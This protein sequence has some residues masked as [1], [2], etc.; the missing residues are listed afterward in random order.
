MRIAFIVLLA[1][2]LPAAAPAWGPVGHRSVGHIADQ[3]ISSQTRQAVEALLGRESLAEASLWADGIRNEPKWRKTAPWHYVNIPDGETYDRSLRE[4][5]GDVIEALERFVVVLRFDGSNR[6]DK[7]AALRFVV[8]FVGDMHQPLHV[9]RASDRGGNQF[10]VNWFGESSNLHRVWDSALISRLRLS[11]K[12]LVNALAARPSDEVSRWAQADP[13]VWIEESMTLRPL[14]YNTQGKRLGR[15][16]LNA[17]AP[18]VEERLLQ[19]GV[20][21]AALLDAIF[22]SHDVPGGAQQ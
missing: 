15:A 14:V 4:R 18:V 7:I 19:A 22:D 11:P 20:R 9:G 1:I 8:H 6:E 21:L 10:D 17:A 5:D 12:G 16:Y 13:V 3:R 2:A